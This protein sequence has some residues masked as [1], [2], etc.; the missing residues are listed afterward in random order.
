MAAQEQSLLNVQTNLSNTSRNVEKN[1]IKVVEDM[2]SNI[3]SKL[4]GND[5]VK[6]DTTP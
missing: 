5:V 3:L 1:L 4:H 2:E 6:I